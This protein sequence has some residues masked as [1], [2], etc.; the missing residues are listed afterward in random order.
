MIYPTKDDKYNLDVWC[1]NFREIEGDI[2][3]LKENGSIT[4]DS[5]L[6]ISSTNPV[7]NKTVAK[8]FNDVMFMFANYT[9]LQKTTEVEAEVSKLSEDIAELTSRMDAIIDGNEVAY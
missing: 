7:Q 8:R 1:E 5:E 6:S 2:R 3:K 9:P 4:V